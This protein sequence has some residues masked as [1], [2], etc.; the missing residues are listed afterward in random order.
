MDFSCNFL[1]EGQAAVR[2]GG[3]TNNFN[4]WTSAR[5][6]RSRGTDPQSEDRMRLVL[7]LLR[8]DLVSITSKMRMK[9]FVWIS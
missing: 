8:H 1:N 5:R 7:D 4:E 6:E 9:G 3:R 2:E